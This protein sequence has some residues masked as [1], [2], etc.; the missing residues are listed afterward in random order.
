MVSM[1]LDT[2]ATL[3]INHVP[4][5][6]RGWALTVACRTNSSS[7]QRLVS[8]RNGR[9]MISSPHC[10]ASGTCHT[11]KIAGLQPT[12]EVSFRGKRASMQVSDVYIVL[13]FLPSAS[14]TKNSD[15]PAL[16]PD[17][18]MH[19]RQQECSDTLSAGWQLHHLWY[20]GR[21]LQRRRPW[22]HASLPAS[23]PICP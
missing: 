22:M 15:P 19:R 14:A 3:A 4:Q 5:T 23:L 17:P 6:G 9:Q 21:H 20:Q 8:D 7:T 1:L 10:F 18:C 2:V 16:F 12:H 11:F 13:L